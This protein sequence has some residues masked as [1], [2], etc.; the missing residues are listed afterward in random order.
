M[1]VTPHTAY[2]APC[3]PRNPASSSVARCGTARPPH[4]TLLR[5]VPPI[6]L[7][8]DRVSSLHRSGQ[9]WPR[10]GPK[11][12]CCAQVLPAVSGIR[13]A[14]RA[15]PPPTRGHAAGTG[16]MRGAPEA[17]KLGRDNRVLESPQNSV[18]RQQSNA[19]CHPCCPR[20]PAR[21]SRSH[22][23]ADVQTKEVAAAWLQAGYSGSRYECL[24]STHL[25]RARP[26][27]PRTRTP[28]RYVVNRLQATFVCVCVCLRSRSPQS[29]AQATITR[30]RSLNSS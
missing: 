24:R 16:R 7:N 10:P 20:V 2:A 8:A 26:Q 25:R 28:P 13:A 6:G 18:Q 12:N 9:R 19:L 30:R 5:Q 1:I 14:R 29:C 3:P 22:K 23:V 17:S 15:A 11:F 21:R 27:Q 4:T